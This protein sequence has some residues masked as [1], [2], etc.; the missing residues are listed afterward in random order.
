MPVAGGFIMIGFS[1][2]AAELTP[3]K[4]PG[5]PDNGKS[6]QVRSSRQLCCHMLI[7]RRKIHALNW[8]KNRLPIL[9]SKLAHEV[10]RKLEGYL[11]RM[12]VRS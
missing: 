11:N 3:P 8:T 2:E 7:T 1:P 10:A 4:F 6:C 12:I 5:Y 9:R